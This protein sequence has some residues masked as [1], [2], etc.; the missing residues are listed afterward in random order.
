MMVITTLYFIYDF[1]EVIFSN[2][3]HIFD[4]PIVVY[5]SEQTFRSSLFLCFSTYPINLLVYVPFQFLKT[6]FLWMKSAKVCSFRLIREYQEMY[7]HYLIKNQH[8]NHY[9]VQKFCFLAIVFHIVVNIV[10]ISQF[11]SRNLDRGFKTV[12]FFVSISQLCLV[13]VV[14]QLLIKTSRSTLSCRMFVFYATIMKN[15]QINHKLK[16]ISF[17]EILYHNNPFHFYFEV[18]PI[19]NEKILK[20][21]IFYSSQIL[22]VSKLIMNNT[23]N[24]CI[25]RI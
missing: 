19:T 8:F 14:T 13:F 23:T 4:I 3:I 20:V 24:T 21:F 1:R 18:G 12:I 22:F 17:Y 7:V 2:I 6:K 5:L 25:Q 15:I 9:F 11:M 10:F 16:L